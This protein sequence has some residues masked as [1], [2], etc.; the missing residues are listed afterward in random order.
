MARG[1]VEFRWLHYAQLPHVP[2]V[3]AVYGQRTVTYVGQTS[4]LSRRFKW[5]ASKNKW[6]AA[7][8][9]KFCRINDAT[10]RLRL[11][12]KL[13]NRLQPASNHQARRRF[14]WI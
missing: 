14:W 10:E 5:Y 7:R 2:A 8:G 3:Y 13:I 4:D 11:E 9:A 1:W 6:S 12:R